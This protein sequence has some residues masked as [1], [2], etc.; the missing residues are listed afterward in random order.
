MTYR[1][2]FTMLPVPTFD[3]A[4]MISNTESRV[5]MAGAS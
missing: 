4:L 1:D 5:P 3:M 2:A